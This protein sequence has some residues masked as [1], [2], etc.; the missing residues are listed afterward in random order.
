[1]IKVIVDCFG[2]DHSPEANVDGALLALSAH[3]DLSVVLTG[4][5]ALL[6]Q[7]LEGKKYD[8]ARVEII[9]APDVITCHD[10][11]TDA[12]RLK[13]ES[14]MMK[15]VTMLRKDEAGEYAGM[16]SAGSTGALVAAAMLLLGRVPG[17]IRPA[18]CPILP[19]MA[20]GIVGICDSGANVDITPDYLQQYAVMGSLYL[21]KVYGIESPRVG[22]LNIGTEAEKGDDLRKTAYQL[23]S[24]TPGINFCGNMEGRDLLGGKFDLCVCDGFSGNILIKSVEGTS[25]G[26][27]KKLKT[28][29]YSN[30]WNKLGGLILSGMFK[31]EKDFMDYRNYGGSVLLG[32]EKTVIKAHGSS[33]A[34][35]VAK[36]VDQVYLTAS[37]GLR[38]AIEAGLA[39]AKPEKTAE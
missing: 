28:D 32:S 9:H 21:R 26:L 37:T 17:V 11:P 5:E 19:T 4:D 34:N 36:S 38:A 30:L 8:A 24:E 23:L 10:K 7:A 25:L 12:I 33:N 3:A 14:S 29:I 39:A 20:G 27:L 16:V 31:K 1:M 22:L 2:G 13:K 15:A 6:K 35:T 18:F